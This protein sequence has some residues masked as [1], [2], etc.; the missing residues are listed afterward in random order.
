MM[1]LKRIVNVFCTLSTT[2]VLGEGIGLV[3][4]YLFHWHAP[5]YLLFLQPFP[6][7]KAIFAGIA[8]LLSVCVLPEFTWAESCDTLTPPSGNQRYQHELRRAC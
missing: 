7:A 2:G 1:W 5:H 3:R 8:I 4:V 6:P